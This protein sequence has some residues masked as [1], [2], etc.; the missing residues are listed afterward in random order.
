MR[1]SFEKGLPKIRL[2]GAHL[3][4][5]NNNGDADNREHFHL[6][7]RDLAACLK[8]LHIAR[9]LREN[10]Q[11]PKK[12]RRDIPQRPRRSRENADDLQGQHPARRHRNQ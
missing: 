4:A 5:I 7:N 2:F 10:D 9:S 3:K 1:V 12:C 11:I 6:W 8:M